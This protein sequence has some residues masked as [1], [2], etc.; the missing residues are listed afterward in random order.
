MYVNDVEALVQEHPRA[1]ERCAWVEH[2]RSAVRIGHA[3]DVRSERLGPAV[4]WR[5]RDHGDLVSGCEL[6]RRE[7]T[8]GQ[9]DAAQAGQGKNGEVTRPH[10][11]GSRPPGPRPP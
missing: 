5:R 3:D 8:H 6:S 4:G 2:M 1:R 7:I 9:L 10:P 11:A